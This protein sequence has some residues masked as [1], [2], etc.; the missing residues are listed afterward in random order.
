MNRRARGIPV[1]R[2]RGRARAP[3]GPNR[4]GAG[5]RAA[6][7]AATSCR[8]RRARHERTHAARVHRHQVRRA[9]RVLRHARRGSC[10][11]EAWRAVGGGGGSGKVPEAAVLMPL[12]C[13]FKSRQ[14]GKFC[15]LFVSTTI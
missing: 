9:A 13:A 4:E 14:N 7:C 8:V 6:A 3:S 5:R 10:G 15:V 1:G 11:G 2:G 12:G